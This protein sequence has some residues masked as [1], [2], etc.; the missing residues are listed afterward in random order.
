MV[1][2]NKIG[3]EKAKKIFHY[4]LTTIEA[5]FIG[6]VTLAFLEGLPKILYLFTRW[7]YYQIPIWGTCIVY[8]LLG[9]IVIRLYHKLPKQKDDNSGY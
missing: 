5:Y 3:S 4:L 9:Y 8:I 1:W 2:K 7:S 6:A